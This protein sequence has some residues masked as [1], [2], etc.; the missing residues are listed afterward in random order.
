MRLNICIC[1][2]MNEIFRYDT[3]VT[4]FI[5]LVVTSL[6]VVFMYNNFSLFIHSITFR[7]VKSLFVM[8]FHKGLQHTADRYLKILIEP[9]YNIP[10]FVINPEYETIP[11][12]INM[13]ISIGIR[14]GEVKFTIC[15]FFLLWQLQCFCLVMTQRFEIYV[16]QKLFIVLFQSIICWYVSK[17]G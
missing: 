6:N 5:W 9:F 3:G 12:L 8:W 1:T 4:V 17:I 14:T 2:Y 16:K 15:C 10:K 11:P 7:W 13:I